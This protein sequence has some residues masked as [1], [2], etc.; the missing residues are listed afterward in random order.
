MANFFSME[1]AWTNWIIVTFIQHLNSP[2]LKSL[3][4]FSTLPSKV[5]SPNYLDHVRQKDKNWTAIR[6]KTD[7]SHLSTLQKLGQTFVIIISTGVD[8]MIHAKKCFF[9]GMLPMEFLNL[10]EIN[11]F[12]LIGTISEKICYKFSINLTY[13]FKLNLH[14]ISC[15]YY[16]I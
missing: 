9:T 6:L 13:L 11:V 7:P 14:L 4:Y 8:S 12:W 5:C 3:T 15:I 16:Y 1:A 2:S 10:H